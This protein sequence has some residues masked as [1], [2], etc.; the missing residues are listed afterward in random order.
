MHVI[1]TSYFRFVYTCKHET[2]IHR[3]DLIAINADFSKFFENM[4][5]NTNMISV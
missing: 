2:M 1:A 5:L 3:D 4:G